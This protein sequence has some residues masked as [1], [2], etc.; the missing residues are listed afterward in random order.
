MKNKGLIFGLVT[1]VGLVGCGGGGG[2]GS[3]A[4]QPVKSF[5]G[6][7]LYVNPADLSVMLVD[8][9]RSKNN[10]IVGDF[11]NDSIYFVDTATTTETSMTTKGIKLANSSAFVQNSTQVMNAKFDKAIVTLTS[12]FNGTNL[13]YSMNKTAA[14]LPINQITG[15]H[16][17]PSDG[18][19][20]TINSDGTFAVNGVCS[21][22]GKL[23]RNGEYFNVDNATAVS[24][25]QSSL[26]GTYNGVLLTVK[27]NGKDYIAGLL[28]N[29][30]GLL[31]GNAP[32]S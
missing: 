24:C 2:G 27:H 10:L 4:A 25:S 23:V 15:T 3:T 26:N 21:I 11:A 32:K 12:V 17:N 16:T 5:K 14:S 13:V 29:D 31:Y 22:T 19:T 7:G 18:S 8:S 30:T 20:W 6:D 9:K 28:G 1:I